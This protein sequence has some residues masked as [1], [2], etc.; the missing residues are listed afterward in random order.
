MLIR[1]ME[2][3]D[4][5]QVAELERECFSTPWSY[6]AFKSE[7]KNENSIYLIAEIESRIVA[8]GGL[9]IIGD[10]GEIMNVSVNPNYRKQHIAFELLNILIEQGKARGILAFTLEVRKGNHSARG[11]YEKLGF[12]EEGVRPNFYSLPKEDIITFLYSTLTVISSSAI[13]GF[14][15][16]L[17]RVRKRLT[18]SIA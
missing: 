15:S 7:L 2:E 10:E 4:L 12:L 18:F 14:C 1:L 8:Q 11:L 16:K 5:E 3:R 6:S 13:F 17:K 9:H